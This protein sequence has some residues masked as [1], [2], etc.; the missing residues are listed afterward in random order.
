MPTICCCHQGEGVLGCHRLLR[1]SALFVIY[2]Q[3]PMQH[4][5]KYRLENERSFQHHCRGGLHIRHAACASWRA[6]RLHDS[7]IPRPVPRRFA[8][9]TWQQQLLILSARHR[10]NVWTKMKWHCV[11][12]FLVLS[13]SSGKQVTSIH[14]PC[15]NYHQ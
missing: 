6:S 13:N 4:F 11:V 10:H 15:C 7:E 9:W 3:P 5:E 14:W 8:T 1:T 2:N 12:F